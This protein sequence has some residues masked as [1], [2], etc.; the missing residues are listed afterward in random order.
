[1]PSSL[2]VVKFCGAFVVWILCADLGFLCGQDAADGPSPTGEVQ[3]GAKGGEESLD[4]KEDALIE[5][6][7]LVSAGKLEIETRYRRA[8]PLWNY[9]GMS[10]LAKVWASQTSDV[11]EKERLSKLEAFGSPWWHE[12]EQRYGIFP[13]VES[14]RCDETVALGLIKTQAK[15]IT[16]RT[17]GLS[18]DCRLCHS[19]MLFTGVDSE[20]PEVEFFE[21]MTNPF[22]DFERFHQD[23]AVAG[24]TSPGFLFPKN[25]PR[26]FLSSADFFDVLIPELRLDGSTPNLLRFMGFFLAKKGSKYTK[27]AE[28]VAPLIP[29][30]KPQPWTH[31]KWKTRASE[32]QGL[33]VDGT[34]TGNLAAVSYAMMISVDPTGRDYINAKD[35]FQKCG[36]AYLDSLSAPPYPFLSQVD[37]DLAQSGHRVYMQNCAKCHG[38][39]E[40][41]GGAE[42]R[43]I[44]Y[45]GKRVSRDEVGTDPLRID[46]LYTHLHADKEGLKGDEHKQNG[47]VAPPLEGI[48]AR[49]PYLHNAS[50]P[51]LYQL[52]NSKTRYQM[53]GIRPSSTDPGNFDTERVGWKS[54]D[55]SELTAERLQELLKDDPYIRVFNPQWR[56]PKQVAQL[57]KSLEQFKEFGVD[58][59]R[60]EKYTGLLNTGH[61]FGDALSEDQRMAVIEFLKCL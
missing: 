56:T 2:L 22:L 59:E 53:F 14:S 23:M 47:Y 36:P 60:P 28:S 57:V 61:A 8:Q 49:G 48:W 27:D 52:L 20:R 18:S 32:V 3:G 44:R 16:T 54:V 42:Y 17:T 41:V 24:H 5:A 6:G 29:F 37:H 39:Y 4:Q 38:E 1:M 34:F 19:T 40:A 45:P 30:I 12:M 25:V 10:D 43:L 58:P 9:E 33:Y 15:M 21:G 31:Y 13:P 46:L 26:Y 55:L 35:T 7:E 51:T 50:V 11:Q